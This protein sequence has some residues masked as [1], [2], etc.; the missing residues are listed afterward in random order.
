MSAP[1]PAYTSN[2]VPAFGFD[3]NVYRNQSSP[4]LL[5]AYILEATSPTD[6]G[7]FIDRPGTDGSDNGWTLVNGKAEGPAT[8]QLATNAT[9]TLK[10]G[11]FFK[12]S[13]LE[14]SSGGVGVARYFVIHSPSPTIATSDYR[15]QSCTIR[16]DKFPD[17]NVQAIIEA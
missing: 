14:V 15:K 11:D 8:F 9:P 5:G 10:N 4:T 2:Q 13:K 12:S 1:N 6:N 3:V 17:G 16:E 7:I